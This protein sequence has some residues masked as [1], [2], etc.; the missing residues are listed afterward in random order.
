M[1][2]TII[3]QAIK[4]GGLIL[5][6]FL[7]GGATV[8]GLLYLVIREVAKSPVLIT[9]LENL[10][11]SLDPELLKIL[12]L[13]GKVIEEVTDDVPYNDKPPMDLEDALA[14]AGKGNG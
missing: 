4:I 12:N 1:D 13:T 3:E 8:A 5:I 11:K 9:A 6:A 2:N 7:G 10:A 14:A